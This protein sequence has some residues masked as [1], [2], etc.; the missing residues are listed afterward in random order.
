MGPPNNSMPTTPPIALRARPHFRLLPFSVAASLATVALKF[1]AYRVT[2]SIGLF[3][4][5]VESCANVAA[6]LTALGALWYAS[7]PADRGH[8]YG[9][10]K[11]EFFSSGIEGGLV[12][13]ASV[14]IFW[15]ALHHFHDAKVPESLGL[16]LGAALLATAINFVVGRQLLR[17]SKRL[18]SIILEADGHHLL[19][20]VWTSLAVVGG[21]VLAHFTRIAWLDPLLALL[22]GLNIARIG[23]D[24]LHRSFD[25]LMDR[26]L[27]DAEVRKIR[28]AIEDNLEPGMSYHALRTRRAGE[29]RFV[30]YHLLVPGQESVHQAHACEMSLGAA[31]R[32]AI[33]GI[34]VTAHIE[35]IEEPAAYNDSSLV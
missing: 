1:A 35:P 16:G 17:A 9:H 23:F 34:E 15:S 10:R 31:I 13:A 4:D 7:L 27:D 22:V 6:A 2:G 26:S 14:S 5:A 18:D 30:D 19:S 33:P 12:L 3:S 24:L 25:G 8:P 21:L 29:Q 32:Q 20:D 28:R 11:I